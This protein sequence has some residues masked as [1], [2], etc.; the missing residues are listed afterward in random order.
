MA[1]VTLDLLVP[2]LMGGSGRRAAH[3]GEHGDRVARKVRGLEAAL[4]DYGQMTL[5]SLE[6]CD[7][8]S[9]PVAVAGPA[10]LLVAKLHKLS[11]RVGTDRAN[12]KDAL[13]ALRLLRAIHA[14]ALAARLRTLT[15]DPIAGEVTQEALA[16][17]RHLFY[18]VSSS[19]S[20]MAGRAATPLEDS[21]TIAASC[22]A[23]TQ[24]LLKALE[25]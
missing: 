3:L 10:A 13:D 24:D 17:L 4:V 25:R 20:Q 14:P 8:R 2:E 9:F 16:Y 7:S 19:G 5:P 21:D 22:A 6:E 18:N 11:D 15:E 23:L 1:E 12:D